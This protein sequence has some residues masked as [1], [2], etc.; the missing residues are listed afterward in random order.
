MK[1]LRRLWKRLIGT[2]TGSRH[3]HALSEEIETQ[4]HP[5]LPA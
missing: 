4:L 1:P 5:R 3:D 2:F